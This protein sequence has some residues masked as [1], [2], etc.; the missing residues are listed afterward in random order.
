V[1]IEIKPGPELDQA[2]AT[3]CGMRS[4][5]LES[6]TDDFGSHDDCCV[7]GVAPDLHR[8]EP[9]TDL[10]TAFEAAVNVAD[11]REFL[12]K[13]FRLSPGGGIAWAARMHVE[14][15]FP[16]AVNAGDAD[17]AL[18]ICAAILKLKTTEPRNG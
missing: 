8:F 14:R 10:N 1:A 9:S 16:S 17:P 6:F 12:I 7:I 11:G 5:I 18:A 13:S 2:I 3:A 4:L 15:D